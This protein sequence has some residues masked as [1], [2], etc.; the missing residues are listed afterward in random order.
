MPTTALER[1]CTLL[2]P[3]DTS[4]IAKTEDLIQ[5]LESKKDED[6]IAA[7]KS[8]IAGIIHGE[9]MGRLLMPIIKFCTMSSDHTLKK[10]LLIYYEILDMYGSDGKLRPEMILVCEGMKK[11]LVHPNEYVRGSTLR[12]LCKLKEAD[13]LQSLIPSIT[14]NLEHRNAYVRKNAVLAVFHIHSKFPN[15]IPDAADLIEKLLESEVDSAARRNAFLTLYHASD[16]KAMAYLYSNLDQLPSLGESFQLVALELIRKVSRTKAFAEVKSRYLRCIYSLTEC[17]SNPVAYEAANTLISLSAAPIA[18]RRAVTAYTRLL[19]AE[20]DTSVKLIILGKLRTLRKRHSAVLSD[21]IMDVLRSLSTPNNDIRKKTLDLCMK[22]LSPRNVQ[23]VVGLLKKELLK[24]DSPS[25]DNSIEY[26]KIL[27]D[28]LHH[29]AVKHPEVV[30]SVVHLLMNYVGDED[31][32]GAKD[33]VAFVRHIV[34]EYPKLRVEILNRLL[35]QFDEIRSSD[36]Y[37]VA[38]WIVAEYAEERKVLDVALTTIRELIGPLPLIPK[39]ALAQKAEEDEEGGDVKADTKE[40]KKELKSKVMADGTYASQSAAP[41]LNSN[42]KEG[43]DGE[44]ETKFR[45][46]LLNGDSFLAAS[47]ASSIT[48]LTLRFVKMRGLG[49]IASNAQVG[50]S[51]LI[52]S[53]LLRIGEGLAAKNKLDMDSR[54][55]VLTCIR[56]L[57]HPELVTEVYLDSMRQSFQKMLEHSKS[58][59]SKED[60][61]DLDDHK[62]VDDVIS[63]RQLMAEKEL[64]DVEQDSADVKKAVGADAASGLDINSKLSRVYQLTG[65][66]DSVYAEAYLTVLDYDILLDI[67]VVNQT[68]ESLQNLTVEL[69]TSGDLK[70]SDRVQ[71]HTIAPHASKTINVSI[72]VSS[73]ES[74]VI[75]GN[76]V[77]STA[78]GVDKRIVVLNSIH[79]DIMDYIHP[80][81]C[82]D[83]EFRSMWAEFEWENKVSVNT[84]FKDLSAYLDHIVKITNMKCLT[85]DIEQYSEC[86]FLAANLYA[87]S[88]FGEDAL[89][90]LSV[91]QNPASKKITGYV[92]IRSKTQGVALSL[93]DKITSNQ[94]KDSKP[95]GFEQKEAKS[96]K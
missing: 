75:F 94:R 76:I 64:Y 12:F 54:Q 44:E 52:L 51:L 24:T 29:C 30:P 81:N 85:P 17:P 78:K 8:I 96:A 68:D 53:S 36:V 73:T 66:A 26:R 47:L 2:L 13:I 11:N 80:A 22:L 27:V 7:M 89:L 87:C 70:I 72:K 88:I 86:G 79:M 25:H 9:D 21:M 3:T 65:F 28:A 14:S 95:N 61:T 62:E 6:K 37:R 38:L 74:G 69:H 5:R 31:Q 60:E 82:T 41:S 56:A 67:L 46:L 32:A 45:S 42:E 63:I 48:K 55:R 59:E 34:E 16:Q 84:D 92:R 93:G 71:E 18:V 39:E 33:V 19:S 77:Y 4:E 10:L 83:T 40:K 43:E 35:E 49:T 91:E 23:S 90:N 58:S 15:L 57:L 50:K 1:E 20:S